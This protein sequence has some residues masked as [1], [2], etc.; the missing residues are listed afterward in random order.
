MEIDTLNPNFD[1]GTTILT[2]EV[3]KINKINTQA[4][5]YFVQF[6]NRNTNY[7]TKVYDAELADTEQMEDLV[8]TF[9]KTKLLN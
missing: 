2:N 8:G 5:Y 6:K 4:L 3:L 7:K 1:T 9:S